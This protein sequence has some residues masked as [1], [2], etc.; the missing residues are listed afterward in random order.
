MKGNIGVTSKDIFPL[1]KKFM[2]NDHDIFIR[3]IVSNAIDATQKLNTL[4]NAD[5]SLIK[6]EDYNPAIHVIVDEDNKTVTVK[7]S[8]IGMTDKEIDSYINQIAFSGANDFLEK[9]S[10]TNIIGHFGLGFYS[11]FMVSDKV[12][13][14][15]KKYDSDK[16][17][18]WSCEGTTEFVIEETDKDSFGTDIIMHI[19]DKFTE[20][21]LNYDNIKELVQKFS[22]FSPIEI[23][24]NDTNDNSE[25]ITYDR[26]LWL[27]QP[28]NLKDE[29][30]IDFYKTLYPDR[31]D[32]LFWIHI[33]IDVPFT[34]KGILYFPAFDPNKPIF[35]HKHLML[36][37]NR[38]FVTDNVQGILPEYLGLLHGI[39]DSPDI[40]LNV[41]RSFLQSDSN[42]KKIGNHISNKVISSLKTLMRKD[43]EKY[44]E[45]WD[46][47]KL[48]V[49]L[50]I[51][52]LPD[53][54]K[55]CQDILLLT[56]IDNNKYTIEE[57]YEKVK[58]N[59]TDKNGKVVYLYTYNKNE[60]Y[61]YIEKLK[62]LKY[63]ILLFNT[64]YSSYEVQAYEMGMQE[65][66]VIFKR[67]DSDTAENI[68]L[69][70]DADEKKT[71]ELSSNLKSMLSIMFESNKRDIEGINIIF[72]VQN[73]G[74]KSSPVT[75]IA[76]EYFRRI[77]EM[78]II[79]NQGYFINK[80]DAL[81][82]VI[83]SDS[84]V[85]KKILKD[86]EKT[87][88]TEINNL[89][90]EIAETNKL[91]VNESDED[92]RKQ[93]ESEAETLLSKKKSIIDEYSKNVSVIN[94]LIDIALLEYGLLN[95]EAMSKFIKRLYK[96]LEK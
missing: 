23:Y 10:D 80:D 55:K 72:D 26:A 7:D 27:E 36:Y 50:G 34:F 9:Y 53:L 25:K 51:V 75:I 54:Y 37:S 44:N 12:E 28:S 76:N 57:Y 1:I 69:K 68:I 49:N 81:M 73:M 18:K 82:F 6:P 59:Q 63:N 5:S 31:P 65:K 60:H 42:V 35:E 95:G 78:S 62:K 70:D 4:Y 94:E 16:A 8:G 85:I 29:D 84:A 89:N 83:N 20:D 47:I 46:T 74:K 88:G 21:Y 56:D 40:P 2:Y 39:I 90:N 77:K 92:K 3:E 48:F 32:P 17:Y 93:L 45:K 86:A 24:V 38:I 61:T 91:K 41:S 64:Q 22:T 43:R 71:K 79:N 33:N 13:I 87:I 19:S 96:S 67:I 58:D 52:T 66:N 15:T 11:S 30:Y 14:I